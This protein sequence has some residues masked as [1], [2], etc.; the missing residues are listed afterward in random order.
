MADRSTRFRL[1]SDWRVDGTIEAVAEVLGDV[2][3]LP[4]W[5]GDVYLSV[6]VLAEGDADGLGRRVAFHSK[7]WL[8]Y[9]LEWTGEVVAADPP[10]GWTIE[11]TGDLVGCGQWTLRQKGPLAEV[12]YV[13]EVEITQAWMRVLAPILKPVFAAN[14]RWAMARGEAGL[15]RELARR[16]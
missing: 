15:K 3:R 2:E 1:T 5:W 6:E 10:H 4:D 16:R 12:G 14:H 8:P 9:T 13:W 11:A 7:G